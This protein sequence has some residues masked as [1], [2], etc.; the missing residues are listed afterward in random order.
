M[1]L[2]LLAMK[3]RFRSVVVG[4]V[5][6]I[7]CGVQI[8]SGNRSRSTYHPV[9]DIETLLVRSPRN[10]PNLTSF[11]LSLPV[12]QLRS[13]SNY[14]EDAIL[15]SGE[16]ERIRHRILKL[17]QV[18]ENIIEPS[19]IHHKRKKKCR[20][21]KNTK[22]SLLKSKTPRELK[23]LSIVKNLFISIGIK[24]DRNDSASTLNH[25]SEST[26]ETSTT[27]Q[28]FTDIAFTI[29]NVVPLT[30]NAMTIAEAVRNA[31]RETNRNSHK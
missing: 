7:L 9:S 12:S 11:V 27:S 24:S 28:H 17:K 25:I 22:S 30:I 16:I 21:R 14:I 18:A 15:K 26:M 6:A 8:T 10:I 2:V 13:S 29:P 19:V 23:G 31:T 5:C 3:M 1:Q 4:Y 20:C